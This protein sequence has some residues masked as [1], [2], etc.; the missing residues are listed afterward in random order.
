VKQRRRIDAWRCDGGHVD[1]H[2]GAACAACGRR[3]RPVTIPCEARLV[4]TTV[5][6]INPS[7]RP[8]VLGVAVTRCGRARTLCRVEGALR[9]NG[10]DAVRLRDEG[11]VIVAVAIRGRSRARSATRADSRRN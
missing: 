5:V 6:R 4:A 1:L 2:A 9:N 10:R 7:G 11:G 8:F 3:V